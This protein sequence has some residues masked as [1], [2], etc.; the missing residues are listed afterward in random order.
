MLPVFAKL[1][2]NATFKKT[3]TPPPAVPSIIRKPV[4][5]IAVEEEDVDAAESGGAI[6][7]RLGIKIKGRQPP[8]LLLSFKG[9]ARVTPVGQAETLEK[10]LANI[11]ASRFKEPT[12]IQMGSIPSMLNQRDVLGIAPTGSGKTA[13]FIIPIILNPRVNSGLKALVVC[14]THELADQ[15][16]NEYRWLTAG[17]RQRGSC[18]VLKPDNAAKVAAACRGEVDMDLV[19]TTPKILVDLL[20]NTS[21]ES[22]K[23]VS[24]VILDE[25]DRLLEMG[26][27]EQV[28]AILAAC[29][30]AEAQHRGMF[31]ATMP[32]RIEVL[33][34]AVLR[35]P[36]KIHIGNANAG[37][38]SIDQRLVFTGNEEGKLS[39]LSRLLSE[40]ELAPPC[41]VFCQ[42]KERAADLCLEMRGMD[43]HL[44]VEAIHGAGI[45]ISRVDLYSGLNITVINSSAK[46]SPHLR[47]EICTRFRQGQVWFL[48]ATEVVGRG[49]DFRGVNTVLNF[50]L[51]LV[52]FFVC[53]K[54]K[55]WMWA[56]KG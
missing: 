28:D 48:V 13:A 15:I 50:D 37:A 2:R 49:L 1:S 21:I 35:D 5:A 36:I 46:V 42:T 44:K 26:F 54:E 22:L 52:G 38:D 45:Y 53:W 18:L 19:V 11:E 55:R 20:E 27:V 16:L 34:D 8:Q 30:G 9:L 23:L 40:G 10:L 56:K 7:R 17:V 39:A 6:L 25:A 47:D 33:V 24:I 12:P 14:P 4:I 32:P 31:S 51:P 3:P 43:S 29:S 41:L